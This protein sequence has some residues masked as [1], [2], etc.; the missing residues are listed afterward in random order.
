MSLRS[1]AVTARYLSRDECEAI[2]KKT[3]SFAGADETR[4]IVN[5]TNISNTRFAVNQISTGGDSYDN[6]VSVR[7][8][9]GKR[10]ASATTNKLDDASLRAV[11]QRAEA[12]AKLAPEDPEAMPEQWSETLRQETPGTDGWIRAF[13][14]FAGEFSGDVGEVTLFAGGRTRLA[15]IHRKRTKHFA[16][17]RHDRSGPAGGDTNR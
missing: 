17:A 3:L 6:V 7:S 5:S 13:N 16:F 1:L 15:V 14:R 2:A 4:V 12:L 10:S 9:F 11:V 8:V